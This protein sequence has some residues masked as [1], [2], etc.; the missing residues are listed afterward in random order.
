MRATP[1]GP[2]D[3]EGGVDATLLKTCGHAADFLDRPADQRCS[4]ASSLLF[5]GEVRALARWRT[6]AIMANASITSDTC[7]CQPCHE[8]VSLWV[9]PNSVLAV[10]NASS[11]AQRWP[12][13]RTS[14]SISVPAGHQV[15]KNARS[16]SER[17]RR[18]SRPRVHRPVS[19]SLY[20]SAARSANAT[21]AQSYRRGPLVPSPADRRVQASG[22]RAFA[23]CSAVPATSGLS[24]QDEN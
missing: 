19:S 3:H 1:G 2:G 5:W 9:R 7:R 16:P 21:Y 14:V 18:I 24:I 10:S 4:L 6:T 15:E 20:S 12:S 13:T 8:R 11:M 23:I 22:A 17:L